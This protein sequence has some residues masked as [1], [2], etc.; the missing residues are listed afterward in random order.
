MT[1]LILWC[2]I[3]WLPIMMYFMLKNETKFKKNIAVGVTFPEE[4]QT[5]RQVTEAL[6]RFSRLQLLAMAGLLV[7]AVLM[8]LF[9][10]KDWQFTLWMVWLDLAILVP[11]IPYLMTHARLMEIKK[12]KGWVRQ[13]RKVYVSLDSL[14]SKK[15]LSP[16]L[17]APPV[18]VSLMPAVLDRSLLWI[19]LLMALSC[20]SLWFGYRYLYRNKAEMVNMDMEITEALSIVRKT[21]WGRMWLITS[22][23]LALTPLF[24]HMAGRHG[25]LTLV[26]GIAL[27][28]FIIAAAWKLEM[29]TRKVQEELTRQAGGDWYVDDD[30]KWLGGVIYYNPDDSNFIVNNRIGINSTVNAASFGGKLMLAISA[31][32]IVGLPAFGVGMDSLGRQPIV[33]T[34][35]ENRLQAK[36]G[37]TDYTI[38]KEDISEIT[39]SKTLPEGLVRVWGTGMDTIIKGSFKDNDGKI[40]VMADPTVPG[41][42]IIET[43]DGSRYLL[44]T[45]ESGEIDR[46]YEE[47]QADH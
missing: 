8:A 13:E 10:P 45:H 21:N 5:C 46:V 32:L 20:V 41:F 1:K 6:D 47:L 9:G 38:A 22:W 12:E 18:I 23:F 25:L 15:W 44:G 31:L 34:V 3:G 27:T 36:A 37:M 29:S 33:V 39:Y 14:A 26:L 16:L 28:V 43:Q 42:L 40:K 17:F 4:G 19:C 35:D 24:M 7:L 30:E 11:Y 2:S